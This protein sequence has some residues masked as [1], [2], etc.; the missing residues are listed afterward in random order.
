[1]QRTNVGTPI[2]TNLP[3]GSLWAL[4]LSV[5]NTVGAARSADIDFWGLGGRTA[6]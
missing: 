2:T 6:R 5:V 1:M 4:G 3:T